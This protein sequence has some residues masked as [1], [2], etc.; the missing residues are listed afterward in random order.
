MGVCI[1]RYKAPTAFT[2]YFVVSIL[3]LFLAPKCA[4]YYIVLFGIYPLI[5]LFIERIRN[6]VI[7]Y[8]I[9]FAVWNVNIYGMYIFLNALGQGSLFD[10]GTFW[11]WL[12]AIAVMLIYDLL[13]GIFINAFYSTYSKY[14]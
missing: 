13:F 10:L 2:T 1:L 6:I 9:K 14:L 12:C 7:E 4:G 11:I 8:I 5:K 3:G